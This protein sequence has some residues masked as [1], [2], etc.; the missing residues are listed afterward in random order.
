MAKS[1]RRQHGL[2]LIWLP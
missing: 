2:Y 1:P